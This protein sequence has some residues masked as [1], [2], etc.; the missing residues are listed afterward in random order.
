V[1]RWVGDRLVERLEPYIEAKI[2]SAL[3]SERNRAALLDLLAETASDL[4]V[5]GERAASDMT[6]R[7][8]MKLALRLSRARPEF[9]TAL[10]EALDG[11]D[12]LSPA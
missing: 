7:L 10:R 1:E 5:P 9:R 8:V 3:T 11:L 12:A 6:E 4:L 2:R